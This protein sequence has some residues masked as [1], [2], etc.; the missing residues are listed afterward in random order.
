[1]IF[2]NYYSW[3]NSKDINYRISLLKL[4]ETSKKEEENQFNFKINGKTYNFNGNELNI[5][6]KEKKDEKNIKYPS[7]VLFKWIKNWYFK[8]KESQN[9]NE[10][11]NENIKNEYDLEFKEHKEEDE[12]VIPR[13]TFNYLLINHLKKIKFE[14]I[15]NIK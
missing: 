15:K 4:I 11:E 14:K 10:K 7:S 13:H 3:F 1:M 9:E 2:D 8:K 6:C 12:V 5:E